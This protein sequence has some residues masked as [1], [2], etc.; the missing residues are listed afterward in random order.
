MADNVVYLGHA[1]YE[2]TAMTDAK[3]MTEL[4][5]AMSLSVCVCPFVCVCVQACFKAEGW[6]YESLIHLFP[7]CHAP[8]Y[9]QY[10]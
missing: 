10:E 4:M 9:I 8:P 7:T 1:V 3:E 6:T 5:W 2:K